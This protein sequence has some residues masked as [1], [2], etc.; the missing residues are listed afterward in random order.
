MLAIGIEDRSF[1]GVEMRRIL[2][3][4]HR[5]FHG[6]ERGAAFLQHGMAALQSEF[7]RIAIGLLARG[8]HQ[9]AG[10]GSRAAVNGKGD[11]AHGVLLDSEVR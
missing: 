3:R 8:R 5:G 7:Q 11:G 1:P 10:D 4:A 9:F 6:I 2:Q